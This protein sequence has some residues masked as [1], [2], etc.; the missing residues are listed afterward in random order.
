[1]SDKGQTLNKEIPHSGLEIQSICYCWDVKIRTGKRDPWKGHNRGDLL[2]IVCN[3][4]MKFLELRLAW[5]RINTPL[6]VCYNEKIDC[7]QFTCLINHHRSP[8]S[9]KWRTLTA[10]ATCAVTSSKILF[11][12]LLFHGAG[13]D[14]WRGD[15]L[16]AIFL[17]IFFL[18][19]YFIYLFIC[20]WKAL[21]DFF[22]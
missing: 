20:S 3:W 12:F 21:Y 17:S 19:F 5:Q 13:S 8:R 22:Q 18:L 1:M 4:R 7:H 14:Q 2:L 16:G 6:L 10:W 15:L 11:P 9:R